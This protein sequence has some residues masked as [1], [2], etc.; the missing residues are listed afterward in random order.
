ML[1]IPKHE[2]LRRRKLRIEDMTADEVGAWWDFPNWFCG[3]VAV[4]IGGERY[5]LD[6]T[7]GSV[8]T[9]LRSGHYFPC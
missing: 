5:W 8:P 7:K 6:F 3:N 1:H 9:V 4:R 2:Y